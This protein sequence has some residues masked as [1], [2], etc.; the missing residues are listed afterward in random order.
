MR[1]GPV[2]LIVRSVIDDGAAFYLNG[3][4][5][6]RA[7]LPA[8]PLTHASLAPNAGNPVC[9]TNSVT[10]TNSLMEMNVLAVELHE[11]AVQDYDVA[12]D[13]G[14]SLNYVLTPVLT[15]REPA[16]DVFLRYSNHS[17]TELRLYW[18]NGMGY[19]LEYGGARCNLHRR[20]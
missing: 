9:R 1:D 20:T 16:G 17:P 11:A 7:N 6:L 14:L 8:G 5:L 12:F 13:G 15:N 2:T 4:E 10:I 19:A 18:T 3:T